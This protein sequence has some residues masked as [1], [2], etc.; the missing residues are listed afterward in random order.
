MASA[1]NRLRIDHAG[2]QQRDETQLHRRRITARIGDQ[3]RLPDLF[4][5]HF[6]QAVH[7]LVNQ[8][9]ASVGHAIPF[10]PYRNV[11]QTKVRSQIDYLC[12]RIQQLPNLL[13][14]DAVRGRKEHQ[15]AFFQMGLVGMGE[16][17]IH[18]TAQTGEH[19]ADRHAGIGARCYCL[20]RDLRMDRQQPEEF[21]PGVT[22]PAYYA[23]FD[24]RN[25][26]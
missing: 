18:I 17:E 24:H 10:F 12:T 23:N 16:R 2:F 3:A 6:R 19:P 4:P 13:H 7:R 20:Q 22:C 9:G 21:Y 15:I 25:F 8:F 14:R 1:I 5:V 26:H 11:L